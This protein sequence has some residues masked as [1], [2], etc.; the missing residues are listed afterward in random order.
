VLLNVLRQFQRERILREPYKERGHILIEL[1]SKTGLGGF[2]TNGW[3]ETDSDQQQR[4]SDKTGLT[5]S[6]L[7]QHIMK[8]K[9]RAVY[10][11]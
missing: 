3:P 7:F 5:K 2:L 4:L 11:I 10:L 1:H 6:T 8:L 9:I